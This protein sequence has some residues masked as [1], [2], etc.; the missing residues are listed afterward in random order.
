[1]KRLTGLLLL[2]AAASAP[3]FSQGRWSASACNPVLNYSPL[4]VEIACCPDEC[5]SLVY[6][7]TTRLPEVVFKI[8]AD[9]RARY[10]LLREIIV[11]DDAP[12]LVYTTTNKKPKYRI[13]RDQDDGYD[14]ELEGNG[15]AGC[16]NCLHRFDGNLRH[17]LGSTDKPPYQKVL[18]ASVQ[19]HV[20]GTAPGTGT[21][22]IKCTVSDLTY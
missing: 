4:S 22:T 9:K 1:M 16:S 6:G 15:N 8:T 2:V 10:D 20:L 19:L 17:S 21:I 7:E 13:S 3:A 12:F 11:P 18:W 14:C 5:I